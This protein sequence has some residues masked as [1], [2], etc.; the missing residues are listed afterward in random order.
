MGFLHVVLLLLG[1]AVGSWLS[2]ISLQSLLQA[3]L[4]FRLARRPSHAPDER[5]R[6]AFYGRVSVARAVRK[7]FG[8]LLWCRTEHQVYRRRGKSSS[9]R[10]ESTE[11][12]TADFRVEAHAGP[13]GLAEHPSEVQGSESRTDVQERTG[14]FGMGAGHGDRRIVFTFLRVCPYVA[15]VGRH[16]DRERVERDN[17]L[18]LFLSARPPDHAAWIEVGKGV[19]GLL[20]VTA[21]VAIA[22][23][24]YYNR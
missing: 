20:L 2:W 3:R 19:A 9:W 7:G 11:E 4:L 12:E 17:K 23:V 22:L 5:G 8:D 24:A 10:T 13:V 1:I 18:G 16:K 14:W 6:Q 15:I 21:V